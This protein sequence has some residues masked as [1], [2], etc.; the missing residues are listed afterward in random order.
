[1]ADI[2]IFDE[3]SDRHVHI[4]FEQAMYATCFGNGV[5]ADIFKLA[6]MDGE[7]L[8]K[9]NKGSDFIPTKMPLP[10]TATWTKGTLG[11][12][13]KQVASDAITTQ[14]DVSEDPAVKKAAW[15]LVRDTLI[16]AVK[17]GAW[18]PVEIVICRPFIEHLTL[19][20][21]V[22]VAGSETG[23]TLFGPAD[24]REP[25]AARTTTLSTPFS[26]DRRNLV[27]VGFAQK[28]L[29]TRR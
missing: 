15:I 29:P 5:D 27:P 4:S 16:N 28:F 1:M 23:A 17:A 3:E 7:A 10:T 12:K 18:V 6:G 24:M 8:A 13:L 9:C 25:Y 21:V 11:T 14:A 2:M 19:S 20:A 22:T 26:S